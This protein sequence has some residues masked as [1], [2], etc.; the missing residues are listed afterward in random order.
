MCISARGSADLTCACLLQLLARLCLLWLLAAL[1]HLVTLLSLALLDWP[2]RLLVKPVMA[3]SLISS[4]VPCSTRSHCSLYSLSTALLLFSTSWATLSL[5]YCTKSS[6]GRLLLTSSSITALLSVIT[7]ALVST[8][9][10]ISS[11]SSSML[12]APGTPQRCASW[13]LRSER[14]GKPGLRP[15]LLS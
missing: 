14:R 9:S 5:L 12:G 11:S 10:P 2:T 4:S 6:E 15:E 1:L 13:E 3:P 8:V 7:T